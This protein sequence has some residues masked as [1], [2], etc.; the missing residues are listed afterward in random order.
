[1]KIALITGGQPRFTQDFITLLS[2]VKGF[3][4][5]DIYMNLWN[6][7]WAT[8]EE[9]ARQKVERILPPNYKL[10]K[11]KLVDQPLYQLPPHTISLAPPEPENIQWWYKRKLGQ[12][13]S[14]SMAFDLLEQEYDAVIR[15]RLDGCL[16][17]T[18]DVSQF[19][20]IDN[21]IIMPNPRVGR[22]DFP[23]CDQFFISTYNGA[24]FF[25]D[26][27]KDFNKYVIL[28]DPNWATNAHGT[29][30]LEH[31]IGTYYLTNKKQVGHSNFSTLINTS[32]RSRYT[33]KHYHHAI[34]SDP[35]NK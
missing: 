24:K 19:N 25:C 32:G 23:I 34:T 2:Q 11:L 31:I 33:D 18:I 5:A 1:M 16:N 28:S 12:I 30:S 6:S 35:T 3:E 20:L 21:D 17:Q 9:V 27:A 4:S 7:D 22:A 26:L 10:A 14:L 29:W 13:Q 8:N 15:F